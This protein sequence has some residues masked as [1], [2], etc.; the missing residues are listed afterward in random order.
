VL[1]RRLSIMVGLL[2][3]FLILI[4]ALSAIPVANP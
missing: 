3:S 2:I 1:S 4:F